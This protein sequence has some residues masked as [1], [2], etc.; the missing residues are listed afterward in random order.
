MNI[1]DI[2]SGQKI[3]IYAIVANF[4]GER[5]TTQHP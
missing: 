5:I 1:Q 2:A 3:V 4:F